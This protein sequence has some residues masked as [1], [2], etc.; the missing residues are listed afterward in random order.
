MKCERCNKRA[1]FHITDI[2][3]PAQLKELH[4]CEECAARYLSEPI[5]GTQLASSSGTSAE[6]ELLQQW[7]QLHCP[8]CG[9]TF[10]DFRNT[11]RLGC[12]HDYEFFQEQL[13]QLLESIHGEIRHLGKVPS[14]LATPER[15]R[16]EL[17]RLRRQM[18]ELINAERYE[19]AARLRDQIRQLEARMQS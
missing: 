15:R 8:E 3:G 10:K 6:I 4:L 7:E 13:R 11:G 2:L 12:P 9:A 1:V 16:L 17:A 19:E 18:Q 14:R 5:P